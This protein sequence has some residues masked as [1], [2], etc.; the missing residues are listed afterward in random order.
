MKVSLLIDEN[1]TSGRIALR[2][3]FGMFETL[4]EAQ[5]ASLG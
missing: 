3:P 4:D 5:M 2:H 1:L